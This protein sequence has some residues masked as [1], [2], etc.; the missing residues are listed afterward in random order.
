MALTVAVDQIQPYSSSYLSWEGV[1]TG[2]PLA[3]NVISNST[4]TSIGNSGN[5]QI[6]SGSF[7]KLRSDTVIRATST[8]FGCQFNS[9]NCGVGCVIDYGNTNARWDYGMAYQY[10][11]SWSSTLQTTCVFGHHLWS[12]ITAGTHTMG[13][14]W[15][16]ANGST[17][18]APFKIFNPNNSDDG[19][20]QQMVSRIVIYEVYP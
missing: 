11:G 18:E 15:N 12:G 19:R 16:P 14:G 2:M 6:M 3:I 8:I 20:N 17:G 7:T 5:V 9:G 1:P 10:D 4:R 13:F